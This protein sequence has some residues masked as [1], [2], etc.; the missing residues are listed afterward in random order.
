M[1][2]LSVNNRLSSKPARVLK[3]LGI[4]FGTF[5]FISTQIHAAPGDVDATFG[6]NGEVFG[7]RANS[8]YS[9]FDA[10]LQPDGKIIAAGGGYGGMTAV[11]YLKSGLL[12][13]AFGTNGRASTT[14]H[15]NPIPGTD[16]NSYAVALQKDGKIVMGGVSFVN[17]T[18]D[19]ALVRYT[20][21][22]IIDSGFGTDGKVLTPVGAGSDYLLDLATQPDGK[23]LAAGYF[24][25]SEGDTNFALLRYNPDGSLDTTFGKGGKVTTSFG[26]GSD[27][28]RAL[29]LQK[30]GKII[31]AGSC[32]DIRG[33]HFAMVR[34][35]GKGTLDKTFGK[36]GKVIIRNDYQYNQANSMALQPDGK[37]L[38]GGYSTNPTG[39][40]TPTN[41]AVMRFNPDGTEDDHF[42]IGGYTEAPPSD[43]FSSQ[44]CR[45]LKLQ[46]DGKII[47]AGIASANEIYPGAISIVTR[48]ESNGRMDSTFG[49]NGVTARPS[50][51]FTGLWA[52]L[53]QPDGQIVTA[54]SGTPTAQNETSFFLA[55]HE[56]GNIKVDARIGPTKRAMQGN[57]FYDTTGTAQTRELFIQKG[58]TASMYFVVQND[59]THPENFR[60]QGTRGNDR[61]RIRYYHDEE[62]IT[63]QV[64]N[65]KL[66][67]GDLAPGKVYRIRAR[68]T[69][70]KKSSEKSRT[71]FLHAS[72]PNRLSI[73]DAVSF[74]ASSY[75]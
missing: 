48:Y 32:Q 34:Y 37:I 41:F 56:G 46:P 3:A 40:R 71:F 39:L 11:R 45:A 14:F 36:G 4:L 59:G 15:E 67:T 74:R 51:Y 2:P 17:G 27:M 63:H 35:S 30:D 50:G 25:L 28:A 66:D 10:A 70:T 68:I 18:A 9:A 55:R 26:F 64:I 73:E 60:V 65:A 1:L 8:G 29:A 72:S 75:Q 47:A 61:Y 62:D 54:G 33:R 5:A 16:E 44:E 13:P 53:I 38:L 20:S 43:L 19:F 23:I 58:R 31:L 42:G 21:A 24:S 12:D 7:T 6:K 52:I 49:E 22:G 69:P 57:N